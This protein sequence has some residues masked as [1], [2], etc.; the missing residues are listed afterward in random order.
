MPVGQ[1]GTVE[2]WPVHKQ[3][4]MSAR[5]H[6]RQRYRRVVPRYE[7]RDIEIKV[8]RTKSG[9][10]SAHFAGPNRRKERVEKATEFEAVEEAKARIRKLTDP[11]LQILLSEKSSAEKLLESTGISLIEAAR[12]VVTSTNRLKPFD[13]GVLQ[14]IDYYLASHA[15]APMKVG[16]VV[17]ELIGVKERDTGLHNTKDLTSKLQNGFCKVFGE[18]I[19]GSIISSELARYIDTY[20]G[21]KR[22]RRN[23]H[24]A[25]IT[26]FEFAKD[27]GYLPKS[28]PTQMY[29]VK[30]PKAGKPKKEA[31]TPEEFFKL[32]KAALARRSRALAA[33]LIQAFTGVRAEEL[34]QT[35]PKKDRV[36]WRDIRLDQPLPEIHVRD[37][38]SKLG[39]ERFSPIPPALAKWLR[40]LRLPDD[41]PVYSED[42]LFGDY[43]TLA[44]I[45]GIKWK[46]NGLRKSFITYDAA[47]TNSYLV[48]SRAAGNSPSMLGRYYDKPTSQAALVAQEWFSITPEKFGRLLHKSI[49]A[50]NQERRQK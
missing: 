23:Q 41:E 16:D 22:T 11:E 2:P 7:F 36:Y 31:F 19:I 46:S 43:R 38:V 4:I 29:S 49:A 9:R 27:H 12:I 24:S 5:V 39:V 47:L 20:P 18:R 10:F 37:N 28:I 35:D 45:A 15:G 14:A 40:L 42:N 17:K 50:I 32:I 1:N 13:I 33:L 21:S 30:K 48:T 3:K 6:S 34:R 44:K 26:L 25:L 8:Y